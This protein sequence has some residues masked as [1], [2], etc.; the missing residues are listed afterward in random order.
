MIKSLSHFREIQK[1]LYSVRNFFLNGP[2]DNT[3]PQNSFALWKDHS[4]YFKNKLIEVYKASAEYTS[5]DSHSEWFTL[6]AE[7]ERNVY[8]LG[9]SLVRKS[10]P[11]ASIHQQTL[12]FTSSKIEDCM[13]QTQMD[14]FSL[15]MQKPLQTLSDIQFFVHGSYGDGRA[16]FQVSDIDVAAFVPQEILFSETELRKLQ[17]I[18]R[19]EIWPLLLKMD[20]EQHHGVFYFSDLDV[21]FWNE[22]ILPFVCLEKAS[23]WH[24]PFSKKFSIVKPHVSLQQRSQS[25]SIVTNTFRDMF[26]AFLR[27]PQFKNHDVFDLKYINQNMI[28][29][30]AI[31]HGVRM[32]PIYK[33][34]GIEWFKEFCI[35]KKLPIL[36]QALIRSEEIRSNY[37]NLKSSDQPC[38]LL[39]PFLSDEKKYFNLRRK[40]RGQASPLQIDYLNENF[41]HE[42]ERLSSVL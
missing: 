36:R 32:S 24:K 2:S 38:S 16:I 22:N 15:K 29:F 25:A 21:E 17:K 40:Q 1:N 34:A 19:Q 13:A 11:E 28:L 4:N 7:T 35:E 14:S 26:A 5:L 31:L 30:P 37:V 18:T 6:L 42:L 41:L 10:F 8:E 33:P 27:N 12:Q 20:P 3:Y 39:T 9:Q 23:T